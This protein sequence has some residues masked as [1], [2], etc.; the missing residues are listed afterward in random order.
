MR[1]FIA[2]SLLVLVANIANAADVT[3]RKLVYRESAFDRFSESINEHTANATATDKVA[4]LPTETATFANYSSYQRG[5]NCITVEGPDG[6]TAADITAKV[7]NDNTT[8]SWATIQKPS[9]TK[10]GDTFFL[11]W[12]DNLIRGK[13]VQVTIAANGTTGLSAADVFYFGNAPGEAGNS[14]SSA[15][16]DIND[17]LGAT[18]NQHTPS[19]P[20]AIDDRYDYNRDGLVDAADTGIAVSN[21]TNFSNDL[22]LI[23]VP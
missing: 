23:T 6:L 13:W 9:I 22:N 16:V 1:T 19:D 21:P 18:E 10:H 15:A 7:G 14:T 17:A 2:F 5:I 4:L 3:S 20:A 11:C 8:S 12:P